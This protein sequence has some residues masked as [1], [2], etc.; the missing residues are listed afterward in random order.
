M[1]DHQRGFGGL[2][3]T[4]LAELHPHVAH[5]FHRLLVRHAHRRRAAARGFDELRALQ[6]CPVLGFDHRV[7][8]GVVV[9]AH[10]QLDLA[11]IGGRSEHEMSGIGRGVVVDDEGQALHLILVG[12][13]E[14][15]RN[16]RGVVRPDG[17]A[18]L[19]GRAARLD[20]LVAEDLRLDLLP[21]GG[22]GRVGITRGGVG[23][24]GG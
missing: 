4:G 3:R 5:A 23:L 24:T 11:R 7:N 15:D 13:V 9:D 16:E 10:A 8:V 12:D 14:R 22:A 2:A 19:D 20:R 17:C 6:E 18:D 21:A 1:P